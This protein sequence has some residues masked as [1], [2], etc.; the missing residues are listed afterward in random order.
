MLDIFM[1]TTPARTLAPSTNWYSKMFHDQNWPADT[2]LRVKITR[3]RNV[4]HH[5][6][7]FSCLPDL[8]EN[9]SKFVDTE[10]LRGYLLLKAGYSDDVLIR[11]AAVPDQ[12]IL[13]E[14]VRPAPLVFISA[15]EHGTQIRTPQSLKF[16]RMDQDE[17]RPVYDAVTGV[18]M[19]EFGFDIDRWKEVGKDVA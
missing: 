1:K 19:S 9:Q 8:L 7:L 10:R 17:Y 6:K 15:T 13:K 12:R 4:S 3:P 18:M 2:L 16:S 5:A 11:G 14:L